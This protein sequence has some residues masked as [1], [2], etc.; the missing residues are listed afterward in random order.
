MVRPP[1]GCPPQRGRVSTRDLLEPW[2]Q[3]HRWQIGERIRT[4]R[5]ARGLTQEQLAT[6]IGI[7]PKTIS[8][9]ENGRYPISVDQIARIARAL[10][11]PTWRLFRDE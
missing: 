5:T 6:E 11:V 7:D 8:R 10:N 3:E 4:L 9:A 2:I 1:L